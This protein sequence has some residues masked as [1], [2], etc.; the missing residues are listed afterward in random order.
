MQQDN[1]RSELE[2]EAPTVATDHSAL[3]NLLL[4]LYINETKKILYLMYLFIY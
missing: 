4:S 1:I 3:N 2:K